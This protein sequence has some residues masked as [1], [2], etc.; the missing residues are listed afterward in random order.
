MS[1][2]NADK[3]WLLL[4]DG[5]VYEGRS[6]GA[7]G[8]TIGEVVFTTGMT[9]C[10]ETLTDPSFYGQIAVQTFPLIGNYGTNDEDVESDFVIMKGYIVREWCDSPSN[11]RAKERIDAFLKQ[12]NTIGLFDIDTRSLTRRL[13]EN[14]VMNGAITTDE[15]TAARRDALMAE[16]DAYRVTGAVDAISCRMAKLYPAC[17]E[18]RY[19][20][21]LYDFGYKR[22]IRESLRQRGCDVIVVPARTTAKGIRELGVDGILLSNGPGNPNENLEIIE[23]LRELATTGIPIMG[24]CLGHQLLALAMGGKTQKMHY[25][26]RGGNQPVLDLARGRTFVTTQNHGYV[27]I[28]ES[29]DASVAVM[30]HVNANEASCEGMRYLQ[31]PAFTVQFHPEA[32]AGPVDTAYLFDDF[33]LMMDQAREDHNDAAAQ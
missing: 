5:T 28:P 20:V 26:H 23:N 4:A 27:V 21:A 32:S 14:G 10:Q 24:V 29:L 13:R 1:I 3:A 16:I 2:Y 12:N 17:G 25:G 19:R 22:N 9:G 18:T 7:E 31:I 8:T 15:P 30:S 11:F 33:L 6:F